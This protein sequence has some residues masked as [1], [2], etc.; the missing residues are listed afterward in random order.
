MSF[1]NSNIFTKNSHILFNFIND[2]VN[3]INM[4]NTTIVAKFE[5]KSE[6]ESES[7]SIVEESIDNSINLN[8]NSGYIKQLISTQ[9]DISVCEII[10]PILP[11]AKSKKFI[12]AIDNDECIGSW[13]DLSL[14]YN[15]FI[16][17]YG[18]EPSVEL[19]AN[20][21]VKTGCIRP[22]VKNFFDKLLDLKKKGIVYKIFMFTAASNSIGWVF[23]LSKILES[24]IGQSF[25]DGIIYKEMIEEWHIFNKSDISNN[26]GYIKNM[27]MIRELI[28]MYD[29]IDSTNYHIVAIDDRPGNIVNGIAIGVS[30]FRIAINLFEVLRFY[31]PDNFVYLFSKYEK[32]INE[33]WENYMKNP[34]MF[35]NTSLD[36]D[37][38]SSIEYI[39]NIILSNI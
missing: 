4:D 6:S 5:S 11:N 31:V 12:I 15:M 9:K 18:K 23:F 39:D 7:K 13:G 37:I 10:N 24:W 17:E 32:A 25:Y 2:S 26:L 28:D 33:S 36:I 20:I 16:I 14:L 21:M 22:Y 35:T 1:T 8:L 30:P 38:L 3:D 27:N 19:F 29:G 34:Y